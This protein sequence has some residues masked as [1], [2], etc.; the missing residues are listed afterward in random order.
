MT[1]SKNSRIKN[2]IS[3][4]TIL[5]SVTSFSLLA[6]IGYFAYSINSALASMQNLKIEKAAT[7]MKKAVFIARFCPEPDKKMVYSLNILSTTLLA[8]GNLKEAELVIDQTLN[9]TRKFYGT[10]ISLIPSLLAKADLYRRQGNYPKAIKT[11]QNILQLLSKAG[12]K[13]ELFAQVQR[14]LGNL[15]IAQENYDSAEQNLRAVDSLYQELSLNTVNNIIDLNLSLGE[16]AEAK[17]D[18]KSALNFYD[19]AQSLYSKHKIDKKSQE[20][21]IYNLKAELYLNNGDIE[22]SEPLITKAFSLS[23]DNSTVERLQASNLKSLLNLTNLYLKEK[24]FS[25]AKRINEQSLLIAENRL[26]RGHQAYGEAL[27]HK[28]EILFYEGDL[29]KAF[30]TLK[31]AKKLASSHRLENRINRTIAN[32]MLEAGQL[33]EA[34]LLFNEVLTMYENCLNDK[35]P[36]YAQA[37]VEYAELLKLDGKLEKAESCKRKAAKISQLAFSR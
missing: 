25:R 21:L 19:R 33:E 13:N 31:K 28:G 15:E 29:D 37:L 18:Y 34:N 6:P 32:L 17:G 30:L 26:G 10:E 8:Q 35:H 24:K 36:E 9:Q 20:A 2:L 12:K 14:D 11:Y 1:E 16:I 22:H 7:H 4:L 27:C 3:F 23:Q 5:I